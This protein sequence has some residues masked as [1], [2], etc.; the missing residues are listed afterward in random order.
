MN[1]PSPLHPLVSWRIRNELTIGQ[2]AA[3]AGV[4]LTTW[5]RWEKSPSPPPMAQLERV[6]Q[7][8]WAEDV[9]GRGV[10]VADWLGWCIRQS[11]VLRADPGDAPVHEERAA[12]R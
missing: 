2:A 12:A 4:V 1:P 8:T 3:L 10:S 9:A 6:A 5:S 7:L 11:T